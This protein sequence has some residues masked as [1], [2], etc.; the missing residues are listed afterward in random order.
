[1]ETTVRVRIGHGLALC[2]LAYETFARLGEAH[3]GRGETA[4]FRVRNDDG[5]AAFHDGHHG[6]CRTKID[7]NNFRHR[8]SLL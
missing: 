5:F 7:T 3:H 1:M 2:E 4:A 6:V 8:N